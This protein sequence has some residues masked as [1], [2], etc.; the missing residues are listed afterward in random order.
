MMQ[1]RK[2]MFLYLNT[3]NGH[4]SQSRVLQKAMEEID[5][6]VEVMLVN[7]FDKKNIIGHLFFEKGYGAACNYMP[8]SFPLIYDLA[9]HRFL[10][11]CFC[12][13]VGIQTAPYLK[14]IIE[15][16]GITDI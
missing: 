9:Q 4:I 2:F 10:Q 6:S 3:G 11:K 15:E 16:D 14:R 13:F 8:G 12:S 1:K 7:G 5:P